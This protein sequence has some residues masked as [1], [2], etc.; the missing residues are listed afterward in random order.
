MMIF[1]EITQKVTCCS[2]CGEDISFSTTISPEG[3]REA[4]L[5]GI[6][7]KCFDDSTFDLDKNLG[8][9]HRSILSL[10]RNGVVLAGGALRALV[11]PSEEI[12]DYDLFVLDQS[13]IP[14]L[15]ANLEDTGYKP[16]FECPKGQLYTYK[17]S[18][19]TKVQIINKRAYKDC[20]DLIA[21]FDITACCAAYDGNTFY[22]HDRFVFDNLNKLINLN[23]VEYPNATLRRIVKYSNKGFKLSNAACTTFTTT[24]NGMILTEDNSEFYID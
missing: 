15:K 22:T 16:C 21:S 23:K 3:W 8:V 12:M 11:D 24:V 6:C 17:N 13:V 1:K 20:E 19:G 4:N 7:E 14:K 18:E 2:S 10:L 9:L 5:S